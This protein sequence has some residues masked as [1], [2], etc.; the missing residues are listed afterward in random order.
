[1]H[2]RKKVAVLVSPARYARMAGEKTNFGDAYDALMKG[3]AP[4]SLG[5]DLDEYEKS[6]DRVPGRAVKL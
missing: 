3:R 6:R 5:L 1:V 4:R 2:R